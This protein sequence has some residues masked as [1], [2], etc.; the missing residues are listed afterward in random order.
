MNAHPPDHAT[1]ATGQYVRPGPTLVGWAGLD[2][3]P[4]TAAEYDR[5]VDARLTAL[6]QQRE[7]LT[8]EL[9][10]QEAVLQ[11]LSATATALPPM[12]AADRRGGIGAVRQ[13]REQKPRCPTFARARRAV[14]IGQEHLSRARQAPPPLMG[15]HAHLR[16]RALPNVDPDRPLGLLLLFWTEVSLSALLALLGSALVFGNTSLIRVGVSAV[17][18]V[19]TVEGYAPPVGRLPARSV[20]A[21]VNHRH[22]VPAHHKLASRH[23]CASTARCPRVAHRQPPRL[24]GS[25]LSPHRPSTIPFCT[26]VIDHRN[27]AS[28]SRSGVTADLVSGIP[29]CLADSITTR[30]TRHSRSQP[31]IATAARWCRSRAA[32]ASAGRAA[33]RGAHAG[34]Q[35]RFAQ[36]QRR[37][38]FHHQIDIVNFIHHENPCCATGYMSAIACRNRTGMEKSRTLVLMASMRS[39][40]IGS[41]DQTDIRAPH[42]K[43]DR[44]RRATAPDFPHTRA[45]SKGPHN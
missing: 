22:R 15:V 44:P 24:L 35:S 45:S 25:A 17:L 27:Y 40:T 28:S 5:A 3:V 42:A 6:Q 4:A 20:C 31:T 30:C 8:A 36:I 19:M 2:K 9:A 7:A 23:R 13:L 1:S 34:L 43:I 10:A 21:G 38:P 26:W 41:P 12:V 18:I 29:S 14:V 37:H 32:P 33:A 11:Q 16:R 39:P